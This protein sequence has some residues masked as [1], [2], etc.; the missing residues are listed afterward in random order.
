MHDA[1][2][3]PAVHQVPPIQ[4]AG[5][6]TVIVDDSE[7]YLEALCALLQFE[8]LVD[9][10]GGAVSGMGAVKAVAEFD[11]DLVLMDVHMSPM[12]GPAA[13]KIISAMYPR[14]KVVLMSSEDSYELRAECLYNGAQ[15][16]VSKPNLMKELPIA[17]EQLG[18]RGPRPTEN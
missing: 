2:V 13:A 9:V 15:S 5:I 11:P 7:P 10:I 8:N 12:S 14:T 18:L 1:I 17:I 16:F 3:I 6:K 4:R